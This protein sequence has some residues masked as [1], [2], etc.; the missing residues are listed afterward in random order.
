MLPNDRDLLLSLP[1][2]E[3]LEAVSSVAHPVGQLPEVPRR[4]RTRTQDEH[5]RRLR[6]GLVVHG[7]EANDWGRDVL[8][9]HPPRDEV[10]DGSVDPVDS[11]AAE[12]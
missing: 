3:E 9:P 11:E 8:L 2:G 7:I 5:D 10:G 6:R 4:I 12:E 1:H